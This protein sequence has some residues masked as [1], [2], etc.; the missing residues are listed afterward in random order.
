[1]EAGLTT[2]REIVNIQ[3]DVSESEK[4]FIN[5]ITEYN[6][7]IAELERITSLE[8]Y[9]ICEIE[10]QKVKSQNAKFYEFLIDKKLH[11]ECQTST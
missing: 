8:K 1:M 3:G 9:K 10:P 6:I 11:S 4:N 5:S 7:S 2:Q